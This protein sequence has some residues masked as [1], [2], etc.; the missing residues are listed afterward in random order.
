MLIRKAKPEESNI[1]ASLIFLAMEDIV[2][3][4]IGENSSDKAIQ[5]LDS[6]IKEKNNQYSYENCWVVALEEGIVAAAIVY[7]G[8]RLK[9]L[10]DP[11]AKRIKLMFNRDFNPEEETQNGEYYIDSVGVDPNQQGKGIGSRIFQFLINE[12]VHQRNKTLGLLV[13]KDNPNAK[14]L[15]LKLGFEKV[16]EKVLLQK[17]M[18]HLQFKKE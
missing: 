7:D 16:G 5:W 9:E 6:L 15:Y 2:Y 10:R 4:F 11:V 13:D 12:Y 14:K 18:E 8:S 1:I 17:T 3:R